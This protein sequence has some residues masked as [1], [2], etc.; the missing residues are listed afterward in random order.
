MLDMNVS[1]CSVIHI[2]IVIKA[3]GCSMTLQ[4]VTSAHRSCR[5]QQTR[6]GRAES[7]NIRLLERAISKRT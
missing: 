7:K 4:Q 3:R 1:L 5:D 6:N 2:S